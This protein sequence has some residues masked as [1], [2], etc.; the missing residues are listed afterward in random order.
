MRP[1]DW[2]TGRPEG[3]KAGVTHVAGGGR[4]AVGAEAEA[5]DLAAAGVGRR[6]PLLEAGAVQRRQRA[7]ALAEGAQ[8][9]AAAALVADPA[10]RR[11]HHHRRRRRRRHRR[12]RR[13][14]N[15]VR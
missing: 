3:R 13:R 6:E 7:A 1:E 10:D 5:A 12:H 9:L 14:R 8:L 4:P 15:C 11:L 2:K